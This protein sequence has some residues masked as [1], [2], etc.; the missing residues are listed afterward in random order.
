MLNKCMNGSVT[1][2]V[3]SLFCLVS[4]NSLISCA[5]VKLL[6]LLCN[7]DNLENDTQSVY[8]RYYSRQN[9]RTLIMIH[10]GSP[11]VYVIINH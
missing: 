3:G 9:D 5:S 10:N 1:K 7:E 11:F 6:Y 2:G 4:C 8:E